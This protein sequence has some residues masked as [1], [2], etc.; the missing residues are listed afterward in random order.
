MELTK[1]D[2]IYKWNDI[3][4]KVF[5]TFKQVFIQVL[6]L[7]TFDPDKLIT[8]ETDISDYI[9]DIVLSQPGKNSKL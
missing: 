2:I 8:I 6:V 1:K 4:Q 3:V 9:L 7:I 5:E